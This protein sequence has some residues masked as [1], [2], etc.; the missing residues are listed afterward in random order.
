[1]SVLSSGFVSVLMTVFKSAVTAVRDD[2]NCYMRKKQSVS[3][4]K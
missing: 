4:V 3:F 2:S 1:M